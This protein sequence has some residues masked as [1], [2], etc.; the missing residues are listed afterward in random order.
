MNKNC[1]E[2]RNIKGK[3]SKRVEGAFNAVVKKG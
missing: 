3:I 1:V 2:R